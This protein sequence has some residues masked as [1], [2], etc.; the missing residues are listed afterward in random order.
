MIFKKLELS[1]QRFEKILTD[2]SWIVCIAMTLNVVIDILLRFFL[3][4]PLPASW[5]ICELFMPFIV[6]LPL[7]Y[8]S[9]IDSHVYVSLIKDRVPKKMQTVFAVIANTASFGFCA[10]L[11][12]WSFLRFWDSFLISEEMM[13]MI[14]L[15]WWVGKM[16]MPIGMGI[17]ALRYLLQLA[18]NIS[19]VCHSPERI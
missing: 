17:F 13:A 7:A 5:E 9:S 12:Y 11:T 3:D 15:P 19:T 18:Q 6:F 10:L 8:T 16:A 2:I 14:K 4:R 1:L